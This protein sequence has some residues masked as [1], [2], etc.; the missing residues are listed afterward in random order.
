L[1]NHDQENG[2]FLFGAD[3][4]LI[5]NGMRRLWRGTMT[6]F[7]VASVFLSSGCA[8]FLVG[9]GGAG[10]YMIRKGEEG[11]SAKKKES[12]RFEEKSP[13]TEKAQHM[14][15]HAPPGEAEEQSDVRLGDRL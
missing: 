5:M 12:S 8:L 9:A 2:I 15:S 14:V 4:R 13:T 1:L 3:R 11:D 6:A 7:L 10:G